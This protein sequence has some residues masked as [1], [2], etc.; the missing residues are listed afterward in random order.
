MQATL[1]RKSQLPVFLLGLTIVGALMLG[2][3]GGYLLKSPAAPST[4]TVS[5][6]GPAVGSSG[7]TNMIP[8][9]DPFTGYASG[10]ADDQRIR[11]ILEQSAYEGGGTVVQS[12]SGRP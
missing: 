5:R 4:S 11:A 12:G 7:Q 1:T 10:S 3:L 6:S 9:V 2:G 8:A